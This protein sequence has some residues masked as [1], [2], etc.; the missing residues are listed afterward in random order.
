[1]PTSQSRSSHGALDPLP[2]TAAS[3]L[4]SGDRARACADPV[5]PS[6]R[7]SSFPVATSHMRIVWSTPRETSV[8]PSGVKA[9]R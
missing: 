4:P 9:R 8:F 1:V 2:T 3:T 7:R 5:S 6:I